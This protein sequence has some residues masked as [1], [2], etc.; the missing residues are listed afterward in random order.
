MG[1]FP[2]EYFPA[3]YFPEGYFSDLEHTINEL[4]KRQRA[5]TAGIRLPISHWNTTIQILVSHLSSNDQQVRDKALFLLKQIKTAEAKQA[6]EEY[7]KQ[8]QKQ[9]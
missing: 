5:A 1:Y 4:N 3:G 6:V 9:N 8:T 2:K 7:E